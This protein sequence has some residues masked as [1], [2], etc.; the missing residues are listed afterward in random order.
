MLPASVGLFVAALGGSAL[1]SRV[2]APAARARRT[3]CH[4]PFDAVA[5]R[6]DRARARQ[7]QL[8]PRHGRAGGWDGADHL[9]LGNVA[10][11]S[12]T[13]RDRS[14]A[15]GLQN[16]AQQLGSSLGTAL[17]GAVVITGLITAFQSNIASDPRVSAEA[18]QQVETTI[19]SGVS[20]ISAD[21]VRTAATEAGAEPEE[22]DALVE[23]YGR[24]AQ[25]TEDRLPIRGIHTCSPRFG[26][27]A[28]SPPSDW[29]IRALDPTVLP[30]PPNRVA[31]RLG[32]R[33]LPWH[34]AGRRLAA[35]A[36]GSSV[37]D[38]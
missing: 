35:T 29:W 11:S 38:V 10:Q 34:I 16:T 17:L 13:D 25:R 21:E 15:G 37:F 28:T 27:R 2:R 9:Q 26:A 3:C 22:I 4:V 1:S 30:R 12:V 23:S 14:E 31:H 24:P 32:E 18:Q 5:S 8:S 36:R 7:R 33:S 20:F 19:A 6:R